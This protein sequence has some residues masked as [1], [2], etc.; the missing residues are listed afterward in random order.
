MS[1]SQTKYLVVTLL[2][3]MSLTVRTTAKGPGGQ[4]KQNYRLISGYISSLRPSGQSAATAKGTIAFFIRFVDFGCT[5][6]LNNFLEFS[7]SL[8]SS[9]EVRD[10]D[11]LLIVLRDE[12]SERRQ[13]SMLTKWAGANNLPFPVYLARE[14]IFDSCNI[15]HSSVV[16][17]DKR[18]EVDL[19]EELP[20][21]KETAGIILAHLRVK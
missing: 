12:S 2:R 7:D 1:L 3:V 15:G 9:R 11:I 17:L 10:D 13:R 21:S 19:S 14:E 18:G 6:C 5:V 16:V 4:E 20:L 8:K